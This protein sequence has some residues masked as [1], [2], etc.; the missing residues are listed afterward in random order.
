MSFGS[1]Y[2]NILYYN[3]GQKISSTSVIPLTYAEKQPL[4][5]NNVTSH[6]DMCQSN[7]VYVL[8]G[9]SNYF[10]ILFANVNH[11]DNNFC[12]MIGKGWTK[13]FGRHSISF[14]CYPIVLNLW[15]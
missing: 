4:G 8:M 14:F 13:F 5:T 10:Q 12:E 2:S 7:C 15:L 1:V 6:V 3:G 11:N 9:D